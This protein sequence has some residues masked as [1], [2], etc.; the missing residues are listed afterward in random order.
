MD[1][2]L[3]QYVRQAKDGNLHA[4]EEVVCGIQEKIYGLALRMLGHQ[5]DAEDETQEILIKVIT[6]LSDF[7]EESAFSSWVYKIACNHLLTVRKKRYERMGLT[8]DLLEESVSAGLENM[9]PL[10]VSGPERDV[11]LEET[12]SEL[13]AQALCHASNNEN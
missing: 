5:E 9:E 3:E 13:L 12:R 7:R 1:S 8:F 6:H 10:T 4:L 11:L 2:N